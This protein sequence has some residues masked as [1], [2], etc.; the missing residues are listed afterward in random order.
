KRRAQLLFDAGTRV[1]LGLGLHYTPPWLGH[2]PNA[3][4][5]DQHGRVSKEIDFTFNRL[6]RAAADAFLARA[7]SALH[8]SRFWAVRITSGSR[9]ELVYPGGGS[10]WAFGRNAQNGPQY[11]AGLARNPNPGWRPGTR[12]LSPAQTRSWLLW[13]LGALANTAQ[14]Q[15]DKVRSL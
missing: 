2:L 11:P 14:W 8:F 15:M 10:Y 6:I 9:S 1:T 12:S 5:V 7:N 3:H 4:F 13:Y